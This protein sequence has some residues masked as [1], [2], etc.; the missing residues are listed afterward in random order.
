MRHLTINEAAEA[1][2]LS[3]PTIKRYIYEGKLTSTKL[4]G[5]QHRIAESELARLLSPDGAGPSAPAAGNADV[6]IA[7]LERWVAELEA[8]VERLAATLEVVSRYCGRK[9]EG[10]ALAAASPEAAD[11]VPRG[12]LILGPGCRKCRALY[13]AATRA[14]QSLGRADVTVDSITDLDDIAA[15]GPVLTPAVVIGEEVVMS[16]RVPNEKALTDLLRR[17]LG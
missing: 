12:V 13:E 9:R 10:A 8:E 17:H 4:P 14:V 6:R 11:A 16:G 3:V 15:Y 7:V 1:L 5:G 2:H